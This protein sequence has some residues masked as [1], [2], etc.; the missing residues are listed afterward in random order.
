M[1]THMPGFQAFFKRF[2]HHFV[3]KLAKLATCSI[4]VNRLK[5][6]VVTTHTGSLLGDQLVLITLRAHNAK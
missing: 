1:S 2:F 5:I 6:L 3:S 4:R